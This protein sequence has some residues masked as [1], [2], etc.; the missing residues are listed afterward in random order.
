MP[1]K[2]LLLRKNKLLL[3][4]CCAGCG[5]YVSRRLSKDYDVGLY[6]YNPNIFPSQEFDLRQSETEKIAKK[7][8]LKIYIEKYNHSEW[9]LKVKGRESEPE[10]GLRCQICYRDRLEKTALKAK[11]SGYKFFTTTLTVSPHKT[12]AAIIEIG[13]ELA[14]LHNLIFLEEDF[15]KKDGFKESVELSKKLKLYRQENCGCEFSR[16][17]GK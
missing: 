16:A 6:F 2:D 17:Q 1:T 9:L 7:Y 4:I 14:I 15:K 11:S 13:R 5:A 3:H 12:A 10:R 8:G